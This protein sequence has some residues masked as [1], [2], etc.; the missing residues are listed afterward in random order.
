LSCIH[1]LN[2]RTKDHRGRLAQISFPE[3]KKR[4]SVYIGERESTQKHR[5]REEQALDII[6]I[7]LKQEWQQRVNL[8]RLRVIK[9]SRARRDVWIR[10]CI[11][12]VKA[13]SC[14]EF[15]LLLITDGWVS[16]CRNREGM[17]VPQLK[18]LELLL[19]SCTGQVVE[20]RRHIL[21][22]YG[23]FSNRLEYTPKR[24][25]SRSSTSEFRTTELSQ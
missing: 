13:M 2:S 21:V 5:V 4:Q 22:V 1:A 3:K 11:A 9:L 6:E 23:L 19:S 20:A 15:L 10:Q 12:G 18:L 16:S 7:G 17:M 14:I 25:H 8:I 24:G